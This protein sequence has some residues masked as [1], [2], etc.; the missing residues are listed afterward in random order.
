MEIITINCKN[1]EELID[2]TPQVKKIVK[3][4]GV[5]Q[6][7]CA[8]YAQG[9]TSALTINENADPEICKDI[10]EAL[11]KAIP[12]HGRWR[13]DRIDNNAVAHIK[14]AI[15]GPSESIPIHNGKLMLSTWQ[16][17]F[18]CNFDG[19]RSGRKVLVEIIRK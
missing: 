19:P 18:F 12:N 3:K 16:D 17:I 5:K 14:A 1:G 8:V 7:I 4:S 2:I 13:H 10:L 6:G 15:I 11:D 9:A